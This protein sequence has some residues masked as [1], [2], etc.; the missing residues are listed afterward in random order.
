MAPPSVEHLR[1]VAYFLHSSKEYRGIPFSEGVETGI[2]PIR[3]WKFLPETFFCEAVQQALPSR[4]YSYGGEADELPSFQK[5]WNAVA[6][7]DVAGH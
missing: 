4:F 1:D 6:R 2:W 7:G 5:V 3:Q